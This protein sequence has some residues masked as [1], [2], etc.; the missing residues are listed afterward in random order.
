MFLRRNRRN[1]RG[2]SYDYW[3]LVESVRTKRGPRQRIVAT[4][5]KAGEY[6]KE[7]RIGW[8]E[9]GR[10]L[11][12]KPEGTKDLFRK[13]EETPE[14]AAVDVRGVRVERMRQFGG[15][16][17]GLVLWRRLKL[18]KIF[19]ELQVSGREEIDWP[20]MFSILTV[21]RFCQPSSELAITESWY[22]KTALGDLLGI[23]VEKV[24]ENR[25]YRALDYLLPHKD[26]VCKHLQGQYVEWFGAKFDFLF[27]DVTSTYFEGKCPH[28]I[29]AKRGYSRDK[30]PE[31]K[32]VCIG[33]VVN[34]EG[35]PVGYEVFDGNR[36]DVT[37]LEEMVELMETKYGQAQRVWVLDRGIVSEDNLDFLR[38]R[39]AKYIVGTPRGM[40]KDFEKSLSEKDW[41]E[42][43]FG[44]E[45]KIVEHPEYGKEKFVICRSRQRGEKERAILEKQLQKLETE[46]KKVK[47]GI[48]K[49]RLKKADKVER[50]IGRWMGRYPKAE[51]LFDVELVKEEKR[52]VDIKIERRNEQFEWAEKVHGSYILRTNLTEEDPKKLWKIYM[53]LNQAESAFRMKKND[54]GMRP[55]FHQKEHRVQAHIFICFLAL[56]MYK[57]LELWM[58]AKGL[59]SSP[60]KVLREFK[61]IRSMDVVLPVKDRNPIRLRLVGRPDKYVQILLYKLG[62]KIPNR[63]KMMSNVVENLGF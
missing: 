28:N 59:G 32:Q 46:L 35:L 24:N 12:G 16:Y 57:S 41:V 62:I 33:L 5:G 63:P 14:W 9:I 27:Y 22:E 45:V 30:R 1:I 34:V 31:C 4:I 36:R 61:E 13:Q 26:E 40:L 47:E 42:V 50:R 51:R 39:S 60:A 52:L 43:E 10:I 55:I 58:A 11:D 2:A 53:Q 19:E 7:E 17:L 54:L 48:E 8:E 44:V 18:D 23:S 56:A 20:N 38:E 49:G 29:Q 25:I 15:V 21:G 37:T 3:T 6:K